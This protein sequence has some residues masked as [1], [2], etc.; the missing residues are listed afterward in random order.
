MTD[1]ALM[2][3]EFSII[4]QWIRPGSRVLDLGCGDGTLLHHL[5]TTREVTGYGLELQVEGIAA[6]IAKGVSAIQTDLDEGLAEFADQHFDYAVMTQALQVVQQP[7]RLLVEMLRV[8]R[9]GV[10]TFP[11]FGH[12]STRLQLML[13]GR[14]P[15]TSIL[16]SEWY[17]TQNI[18]LCTLKDF[19]ALCDKLN[20]RIL[21]RHVTDAAH[22]DSLSMRWLPNLTGQI[23][24]YM[25]ARA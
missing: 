6:C 18:H 16:P 9:Q 3:P 2:K 13:S 5:Q 7:D 14:M 1:A 12:W 8:A 23:G 19:E 21:E 10:V 17:D 24:I 22:Q 11:N 20:L 4:S 15:K 25:L